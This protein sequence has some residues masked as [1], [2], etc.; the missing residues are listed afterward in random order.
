MY[1]LHGIANFIIIENLAKDSA[2]TMNL[3]F[4]L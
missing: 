4:I 1:N 2:F 3:T